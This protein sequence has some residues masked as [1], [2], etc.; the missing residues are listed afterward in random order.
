MNLTGFKKFVDRDYGYQEENGPDNNRDIDDNEKP[1]N[2]GFSE[3]VEC[4]TL[5]KEENHEEKCDI[6]QD[7][8]KR[9]VE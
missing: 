3:E 6:G 1:W 5:H 7:D 8:D 4:H 9:R 2:V